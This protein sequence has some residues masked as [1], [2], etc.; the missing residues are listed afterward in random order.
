VKSDTTL[1]GHLK[2]LQTQVLM[3]QKTVAVLKDFRDHILGPIPADKATLNPHPLAIG[4]ISRLADLISELG[5]ANT[6]IAEIVR[7]MTETL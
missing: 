2:N 6:T 5:E 3:A 4:T 7:L 1:E